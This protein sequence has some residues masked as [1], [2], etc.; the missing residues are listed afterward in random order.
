MGDHRELI[1][2]LR[3]MRPIEVDGKEYTGAYF[4]TLVSLDPELTEAESAQTPQIIAELG[5]LVARAYAQKQRIELEYRIW[6]DGTIYKVTNDLAAAEKAGFDCATGDKAKCPS[7]ASAEAWMRTTPE[8]RRHNENVIVAEEA[9]QTVN[10]A[11]DAAKARSWAIRGFAATGGEASYGRPAGDYPK[12]I[13]TAAAE[14]AA[15]PP[16]PPKAP[17]PPPLPTRAPA[18]PPPP[19]P[20]KA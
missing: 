9:W 2:G 19:P 11:L 13:E 15:Y 1:T 14:D 4:A 6:R 5:R 20:R 16:E 8:Y 17:G 3:E 7:N 12:R 10:V 18:P